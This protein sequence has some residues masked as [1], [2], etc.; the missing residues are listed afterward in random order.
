MI[1]QEELEEAAGKSVVK[2]ALL[3]ELPDQDE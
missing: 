3:P 2:A 1:P